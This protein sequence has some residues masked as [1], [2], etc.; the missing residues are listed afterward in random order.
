MPPTASAGSL[1]PGGLCCVWRQVWAVPPCPHCP[2]SSLAPS[3]SPV[4]GLS[5]PGPLCPAPRSFQSP[6]TSLFPLFLN[7]WAST[8]TPA[9]REGYVSFTLK[10][11][12]FQVSAPHPHLWANRL[13]HNTT[14]LSWSNDLGMSSALHRILVLFTFFKPYTGQEFLHR[15]G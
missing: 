6:L 9:P 12:I 10:F 5:V 13:P 7:C 8:L 11:H 15:K 14:F 3:R 1:L 4:L 2:W